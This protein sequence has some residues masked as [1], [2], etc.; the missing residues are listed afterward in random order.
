MASVLHKG[1]TGD[2]QGV[3]HCHRKSIVSHSF[4][5]RLP[6]RFKAFLTPA[7]QFYNTPASGASRT[8]DMS[9]LKVGAHLQTLIASDVDI[10]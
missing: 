10:Q 2:I 3:Q 1:D 8:L 7:D 5:Q 6:D 4:I 9:P